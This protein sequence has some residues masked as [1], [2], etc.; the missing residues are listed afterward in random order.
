MRQVRGTY[1]LELPAHIATRH[2]STVPL[3]NVAIVW[4][5]DLPVEGLTICPAVVH[6]GAAR[7]WLQVEDATERGTLDNGSLTALELAWQQRRE[8][9]SLRLGW[10]EKAYTATGGPLSKD[11][12]EV[13]RVA[14][15]SNEKHGLQNKGQRWVCKMLSMSLTLMVT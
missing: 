14:E 10:C 7:G 5:M 2:E 3:G 4:M 6:T 1:L 13:L 9:G 8:C 11:R 15:A 12:L